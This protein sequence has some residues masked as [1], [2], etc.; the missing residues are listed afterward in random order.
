MVGLQMVN[1]QVIGLAAGEGFGEV[2]HPLLPFPSIHRIQHRHF[3][4]QDDIGVIRNPFG[5]NVLAFEQIEVE[6]I[7]TDILHIFV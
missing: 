1:H 4:I 6:V 7:D 3:L 2:V 5:N